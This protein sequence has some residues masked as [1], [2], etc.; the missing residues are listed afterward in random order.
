M[1]DVAAYHIALYTRSQ[2]AVNVI[3]D[4]IQH[5]YRVL[6]ISLVHNVFSI[7]DMQRRL[8]HGCLAV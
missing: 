4:I 1:H 7:Y 8:L 3:Q 6:T 5:C 2:T